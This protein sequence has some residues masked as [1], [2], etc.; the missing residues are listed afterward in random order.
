MT[1]TRVDCVGSI[2]TAG[3]STW[4]MCERQA[5]KGETMSELLSK[6]ETFVRRKMA[7]RPHGENSHRDRVHELLTCAIE[8]LGEVAR[9]IKRRFWRDVRNERD[10]LREELGDTLFCVVGLAVEHGFTVRELI[11]ANQRKLEGR[12]PELKH[13]EPQFVIVRTACG[14]SDYWQGGWWT[15]DQALALRM[16]YVEAAKEKWGFAEKETD[17]EFKVVPTEGAR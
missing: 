7:I 4:F 17:C 3:F 15:A 5:Q 2:P 13:A 14:L 6:Y 16:S 11:E 10:N 12:Y 1:S 9:N 8:E